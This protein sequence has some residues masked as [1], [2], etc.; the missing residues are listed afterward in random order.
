M[1]KMY[2]HNYAL[3]PCLLAVDQLS[4]RVELADYKEVELITRYNSFSVFC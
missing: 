4:P 2:W 3:R 1:T